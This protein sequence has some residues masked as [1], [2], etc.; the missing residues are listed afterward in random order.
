MPELI[1]SDEANRVFLSQPIL[2]GIMDKLKT[3]NGKEKISALIDRLY[4]LNL[5]DQIDPDIVSKLLS[6][7]GRSKDIAE[8]EIRLA[9]KA[10]K[11][12]DQYQAMQHLWHVV[13][14][15]Y[16]MIE[17]TESQ[18][19]FVSATLK[20]SDLCF[21]L[22]TGFM[23]LPRFLKK[24]LTMTEEM[25]RPAFPRIGEFKSFHLFSYCPATR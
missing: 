22:G 20:L 25:G 2:P 6:Q 17:D 4:E 8:I 13:R 3:L 21:S 19:L 18:Q 5:I 12:R 9:R 1:K 14:Q 23:E 10:L 24:A 15:L 11:N 16:D 7:A